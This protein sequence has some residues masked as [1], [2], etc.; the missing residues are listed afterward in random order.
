MGKINYMLYDNTYIG[1]NICII[2]VEEDVFYI[3]IYIYIVII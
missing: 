2:T 3:Y 1:W